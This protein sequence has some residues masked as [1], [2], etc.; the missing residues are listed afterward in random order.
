MKINNDKLFDEIAD[1]LARGRDVTITVRGGS[2]RPL[3][4]DGRDR[5]TLRRP[6]PGGIRRGDV[7]LVRES[8]GGGVVLHRVVRRSGD[9]LVL[10]G[11]GNRVQTETAAVAD[12]VGVAVSFTRRGKTC[13]SRALSWR[14]LSLLMLV[15]VSWRRL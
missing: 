9:S 11:D 7:V 6:Q 12:V 13:S 10:Q 4:V 14:L 8:G 3:L 15:F 2:M 5:V 1:L